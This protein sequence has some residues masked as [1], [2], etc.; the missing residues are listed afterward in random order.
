MLYRQIQEYT[1]IARRTLTTA[2]LDIAAAHG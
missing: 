1:H 2:V